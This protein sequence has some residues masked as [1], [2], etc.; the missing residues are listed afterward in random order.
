MNRFA[1]FL[2][3]ALLFSAQLSVADPVAKP[4]LPA[5]AVWV[6]RYDAELDGKVTGK[7]EDA[8]RWA[9]AVRNDRVSGSLAGLRAGDPTDHRLAGEIAPGSPPITTLRQDGP[10]SLV[11][12][13]T[14]KRI[15]PDRI[16]G[17]WF[18]NRGKS[19]DFEMVIEK[20]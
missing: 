11:C 12:Y 16:V 14:G 4:L 20:K 19:G 2:A 9:F 18:D 17:T 7:V 1:A 3:I 15:E 6:M 5:E 13:Y 8:V 10:G